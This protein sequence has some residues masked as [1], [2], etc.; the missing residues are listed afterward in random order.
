M[1]NVQVRVMATDFETHVAA[2]VA[3]VHLPPLK[4]GDRM[5]RAEF[6]RR[7]EAT[8]HLKK[9]ELIEGVVYVP[10]PVSAGHSRGHSKLGGWLEVCSASTPGTEAGNNAT[11]RLDED[12]EPQP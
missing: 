1:P 7:Y 6:E 4:T 3:S 10:P 11:F 2:D 8:P 5:T 9:A 12:N